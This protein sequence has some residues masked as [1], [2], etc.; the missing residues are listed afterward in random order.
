[1]KGSG[2]KVAGNK[3]IIQALSFAEHMRNVKW[4]WIHLNGKVYLSIM[5]IS[6]SFL[7]AWKYEVFLHI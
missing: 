4:I 7:P 6:S 2:R 5:S 1:M 3:F